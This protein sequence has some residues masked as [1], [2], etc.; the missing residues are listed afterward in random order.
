MTTNLTTEYY[1]TTFSTL[2]SFKIVSLYI[3][4]KTINGINISYYSNFNN[5]IGGNFKL[6]QF[7]NDNY[8]GKTIL[9][10][11]EKNISLNFNNEKEG[12]FYEFIVN[13]DN[14]IDTNIYKLIKSK[15]HFQ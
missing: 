6:N 3:D 1:N 15:N 7:I 8:S 14:I 13:N 5:I 4:Y 10:N 9:L 2:G 11:L 12:N